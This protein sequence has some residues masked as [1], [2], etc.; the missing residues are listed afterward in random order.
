MCF[1]EESIAEGVSEFDAPHGVHAVFAEGSTG[2]TRVVGIEVVSTGAVHALGWVA[3]IAGFAFGWVRAF[4][5]GIVGVEVEVREA[6][7]AGGGVG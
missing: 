4:S 2:L 7:C 3:G 5:A 6:G 1:F